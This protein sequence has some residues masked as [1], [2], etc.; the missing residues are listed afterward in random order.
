ME[1]GENDNPNEND[2]GDQNSMEIG[3]SEMEI[4]ENQACNQMQVDHNEKQDGDDDDDY[5]PPS[6]KWKSF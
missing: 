6:K 1:I 5:E 3:E 4:C 2:N